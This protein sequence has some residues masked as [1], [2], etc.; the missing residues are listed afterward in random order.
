MANTKDT[1]LIATRNVLEEDRFICVG[2]I[3]GRSVWLK[4]GQKKF[5]KI[6]GV[7]LHKIRLFIVIWEYIQAVVVVV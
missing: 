2:L 3:H 1:K 5:D 7:R 4:V 6:G